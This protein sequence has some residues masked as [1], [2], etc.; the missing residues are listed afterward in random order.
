MLISTK[1]SKFTRFY[2]VEVLAGLRVSFP[3]GFN[4][5]VLDGADL[6]NMLLLA[7]YYILEYYIS[8][9]TILHYI[10]VLQCLK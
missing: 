10:T 7:E 9:N 6:V 3:T 1:L 5:A 2:C 4:V 8:Q